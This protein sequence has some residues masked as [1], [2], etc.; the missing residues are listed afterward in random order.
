[1]KGSRKRPSTFN[2]NAADETSI[3]PV[4]LFAC[5]EQEPKAPLH[6]E[7]FLNQKFEILPLMHPRIRQSLQTSARKD[8]LEFPQQHVM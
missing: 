3:Y 8:L 4:L 5:S 6:F 1:M 2:C 7:I